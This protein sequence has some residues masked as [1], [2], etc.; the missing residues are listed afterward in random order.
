MGI[1]F[2]ATDQR[3]RLASFD[4]KNIYIGHDSTISGSYHSGSVYDQNGSVI[5][6]FQNNALH[7]TFKRHGIF[8][9]K[10]NYILKDNA[11]IA[12]FQGS[13]EGA[14]AA[15]YL[16]YK[17]LTDKQC[18]TRQPAKADTT[19]IDCWSFSE[20]WKQLYGKS[21]TFFKVLIFAIVAL[22]L[23]WLWQLP[24]M[25]AL[26]LEES[27]GIIFCIW[28]GAFLYCFKWHTYPVFSKVSHIIK[29]LW[30]LFVPYLHAAWITVVVVCIFAVANNIFSYSYFADILSYL[31]M[32]FFPLTTPLYFIH[33]VR[34]LY[35]L[36][37]NKP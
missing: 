36:H 33:I 23:Y 11:I 25:I 6:T 26:L 12:T 9:I 32:L 37:K 27:W 28:G 19:A 24:M 17:T 16:Y 3:V 1:I 29:L 2:S 10:N 21:T 8:V 18:Y 7:P 13:G 30:D 14:C 22:C 5:A 31:P 35:L 4:D 20:L 34:L 15:A